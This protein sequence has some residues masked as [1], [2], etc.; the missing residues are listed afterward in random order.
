MGYSD[1]AFGAVRLARSLMEGA[2]D[3]VPQPCHV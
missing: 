3:G 1:T 2:A